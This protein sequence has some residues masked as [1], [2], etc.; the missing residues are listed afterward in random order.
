MAFIFP[1]GPAARKAA[2]RWGA[3]AQNIA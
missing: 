1:R 3:L 2:W